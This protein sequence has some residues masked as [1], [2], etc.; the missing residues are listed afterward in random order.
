MKNGICPKCGNKTVHSG[1]TLPPKAKAGPDNLNTI[2]LT[3]GTFISLASLDNYV[4]TTCGYVESYISDAHKLHKIEQQ[5][6]RVLTEEESEQQQQ[7]ATT[8]SVD[9]FEA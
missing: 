6:P 3:A 2:P 9:D 8:T 5:W 4:C 7:Q 1:A